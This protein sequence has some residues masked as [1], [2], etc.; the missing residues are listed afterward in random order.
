[1]LAGEHV[2]PDLMWIGAD[3]GWLRVE[4]AILATRQGGG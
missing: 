1:M 4:Q 2:M 3:A